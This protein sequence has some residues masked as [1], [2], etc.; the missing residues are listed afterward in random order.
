MKGSRATEPKDF[1]YRVVS[2]PT[3]EQ[4]LLFPLVLVDVVAVAVIVDN[5]ATVVDCPRP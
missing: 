1:K 2:N 4:P 3:T 5:G